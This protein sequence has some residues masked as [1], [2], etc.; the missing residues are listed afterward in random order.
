[1]GFRDE[2][3]EIEGR[4]KFLKRILLCIAVAFLVA[5]CIFSL[6]YPA[7]TWKYYVG[8][9]KI[10]KRADGEMRIHFLSVGQ[11]DATLIELPDGKTALIDGGDGTEATA[12]TVLRYLNALK[13]KTL[14]YLIV[15]H[16]DSEHCGSLDTVLSQKKVK[17]VYL[18]ACEPTVDAEYASFFSALQEMDCEK[19]YASRKEKL[20][21]DDDGYTFSFL[22]PY[23]QEVEDGYFLNSTSDA[24][25]SVLWLDYQGVS[26]LF[27]GDAPMN[28]ED[29][30]L[31]EEETLGALSEMGIF[32]NST[33]ILKVAH[34]GSEKSTGESFLTYL[35]PKTA[36]VSCDDGD[37]YGLPSERVLQD[38]HD[39]GAKT[40]RTDRDGHILVTVTREGIYRCDKIEV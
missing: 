28:R 30:L 22:L 19:R 38:L 8:K 13:I 34:H 35:Q 12:K 20:S 18:P 40:Y 32:L 10:E 37:L 21:T 29:E 14:D 4:I 6:F 26:A 15:T 11:G 5:L 7:W 3:N 16:A 9:P 27:M 17:T 31:V 36:V 24:S 39:V 2:K 1:M 33:E 25:S 23:A